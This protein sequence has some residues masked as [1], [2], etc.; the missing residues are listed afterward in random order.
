MDVTLILFLAA[1][2]T[3]LVLAALTRRQEPKPRR[4]RAR[5]RREP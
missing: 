2:L 4:V 3:A 5:N 1:P